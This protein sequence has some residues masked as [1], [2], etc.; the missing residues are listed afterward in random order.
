VYCPSLSHWRIFKHLYFLIPDQTNP[1]IAAGFCTAKVKIG[2]TQIDLLIW[3]TAGQ[4]TYRAITAQYYRDAQIIFIV[5]DV[6]NAASFAAAGDWHTRATEANT[7]PVIILVGNKSDLPGR[8]I[9]ESQGE[10]M[11]AEMKALYRETSAISGRGIS[12]LFED[13]GERFLQSQNPKG[14]GAAANA[15]DLESKTKKS[16]C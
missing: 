15:V 10:A 7:N 5:F 4:E 13:A 14:D 16:C 9:S 2:D 3:D 8:V 11:G 1:T 6:T 12:A